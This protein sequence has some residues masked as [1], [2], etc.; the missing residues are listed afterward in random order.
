[1]PFL[2]VMKAAALAVLSCTSYKA[3]R[4]AMKEEAAAAKKTQDLAAAPEE[5]YRCICGPP[6]EQIGLRPGS[7][8]PSLD[9]QVSHGVRDELR[10]LTPRS[11]QAGNAKWRK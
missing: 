3:V 9:A 1:M 7:V 6:Y 2:T 8:S 4:N 11:R 10:R 5:E